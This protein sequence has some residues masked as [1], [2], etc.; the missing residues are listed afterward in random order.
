[1]KIVHISQAQ[2]VELRADPQTETVV[3]KSG[4]QYSLTFK[5]EGSQIPFVRV[6]GLSEY[7]LRNLASQVVLSV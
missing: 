7:Q 1:V 2:V 6:E 4:E 3:K 5:S